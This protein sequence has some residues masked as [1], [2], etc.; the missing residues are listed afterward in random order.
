M[1]ENGN[2]SQG[3]KETQQNNKKIDKLE[4]AKKTCK[5]SQDFDF[6]A[7]SMIMKSRLQSVRLHFTYAHFVS[8]VGSRLQVDL[9][10]SLSTLVMCPHDSVQ[11]SS[12]N[13]HYTCQRLYK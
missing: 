8:S 3:E 9:G 7:C 2:G 5:K 12:T 4:S 11:D 13:I 6:S 1:K 10:M